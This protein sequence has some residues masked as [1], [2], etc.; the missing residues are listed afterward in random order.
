MIIC[1]SLCEDNE[2]RKLRMF[3]P[4]DDSVFRAI[5][6][7]RPHLLCTVFIIRQGHE[8]LSLERCSSQETEVRWQENYGS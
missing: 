8:P 4:D 2:W 5:L 3:A 1:F 6:K 7:S